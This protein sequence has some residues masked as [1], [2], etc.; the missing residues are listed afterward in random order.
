[1]RLETLAIHAIVLLVLGGVCAN[2]ATLVFARTV[3]REGEIAV[4]MA[5][6]ANGARIAGLV[7][8]NGVGLAIAGIAAGTLAAFAVTRVLSGLLYDVTPTDPLTFA[9]AAALLVAVA[10]LACYIPAR[11][12]SR[13]DPVSIL[14]E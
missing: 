3:T 6:G 13:V 1:M 9:S 5:L 4:R 2:V 7:L 12:A 8:R 14:R 10:A 11:Q